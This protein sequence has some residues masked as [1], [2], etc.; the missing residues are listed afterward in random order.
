MAHVATE[1]LRG[2]QML[3]LR[4]KLGCLPPRLLT[5]GRETAFARFVQSAGRIL[6]THARTHAQARTPVK[7]LSFLY[8]ESTVFLPFCLKRR[9]ITVY[10]NTSILDDTQ[11]RDS[12]P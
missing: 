10:C 7:V 1:A 8:L 6:Q 12:S 4:A 2:C 11:T 5:T 9:T 3:G